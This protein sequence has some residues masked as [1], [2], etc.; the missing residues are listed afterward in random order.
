MMLNHEEDPGHVPT[1]SANHEPCQPE[2]D[3]PVQESNMSV[4]LKVWYQYDFGVSD[5]PKISGNGLRCKH[6]HRRIIPRK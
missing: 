2:P 5:T 1:P 6:V 4:N 3:V